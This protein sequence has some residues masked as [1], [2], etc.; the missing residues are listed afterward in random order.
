MADDFAGSTATIGSINVGGIATGDIEAVGD[1]DWFRISLVAGH[2]YTF[3]LSG[4]ATGQGTLPD[5]FLRLRDSVGTSLAFNDDNGT[6]LNSRVSFTATTGGTYYL[7]TGSATTTGIGTYTLSAA[8]V[9]PPSTDD[10]AGSTATLGTVAVGGSRTGNI[11]TVGD[12]D[13]FRISLVAGHTYTF[14]LSGA[15]TGQGT[16]PDPFLRLRDSVGTSLAFNDDNGTNLNSRVSFTATTGGTYYLSTGSATTTGIGTYTLSAADVTPPPTITN[17]IAISTYPVT[18]VMQIAQGNR[19]NDDS[20][21]PGTPLQWGYDFLA[22]NQP[23]K[24]VAGA[25]S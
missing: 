4:A 14:N 10:F 11:E 15:A 24:A 25:P 21:L 19:D 22:A 7:S 2:T 1:T 17:P 6:N 9:T 23:V 8:D 13:W 3:N 5:P 16:L 12:T 20:H 18:G